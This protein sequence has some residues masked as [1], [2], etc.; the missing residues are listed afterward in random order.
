MKREIRR[1][2]V[3]VLLCGTAAFVSG[4]DQTRTDDPPDAVPPGTFHAQAGQSAGGGFEAMEGPASFEISITTE[5]APVFL[6]RLASRLPNVKDSTMLDFSIVRKSVPGAEA[7]GFGDRADGTT[8]LSA[9]FAGCYRSPNFGPDEYRSESGELIVTSA[10]AE[11]F[12]GTFNLVTYTL[13]QTGPNSSERIRLSITG[14]FSAR[15]R[16]TG[17]NPDAILGCGYRIHKPN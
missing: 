8:D 10:N 12:K 7:Y 15:P 5:G 6:M 11:H 2:R 17:I 13:V 4:C 3:L 14:T 9:V 1:C 16:S